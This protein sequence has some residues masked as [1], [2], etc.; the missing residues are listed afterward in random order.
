MHMHVHESIDVSAITKDW[1]QTEK[2]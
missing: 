2:T 1:S